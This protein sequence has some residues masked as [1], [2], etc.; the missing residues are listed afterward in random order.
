MLLI[1]TRYHQLLEANDR[2]QK[3]FKTNINNN[4][5]FFGLSYFSVTG[6]LYTSVRTRASGKQIQIN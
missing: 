5:H 1:L 6:F 4:K 3:Q 2:Y